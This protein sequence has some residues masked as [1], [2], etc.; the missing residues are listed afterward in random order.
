MDDEP[1][2]VAAL[3]IIL[4]QLGYR[5][6]ALTKGQDALAAFGADPDG[7]DL[8]ITDL[9]MPQLTGLDLAYE[10]LALRP[11]SPSS[12]APATA[13]PSPWKKARALGIRGIILKP[14]MPTQMA[15]TIRQLLDAARDRSQ[16][17]LEPE[18]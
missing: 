4:E 1:D 12:P 15:E 11:S 16:P 18:G 8:V 9:T 7:F 6:V 5:V 13:N 14:I 10:I 17:N 2:I 3:Q